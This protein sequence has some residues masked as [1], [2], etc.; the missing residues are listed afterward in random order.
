[1]RNGKR[2]AEAGM[3]SNTR[4][5]NKICGRLCVKLTGYLDSPLSVGSGEQEETDAD[6]LLDARGVPFIPG[7]TLAGALRA[8]NKELG[9][10]KESDQLFGTPFGGTPG[11]KGD[12]QSRI[13]C[14]DTYLNNATTSI[15]NGVKL[16]KNKTAESGAK[17]EI[18]VI[19][20]N[21][22]FC[23]RIEIIE[24]ED[25]LSKETNIQEVGNRDRL[26]VKRW[27]H[28]F[29]S[30][31]LRIGSRSNRGFGKLI[32]ESAKVKRFQMEQQDD[33]LEG[34]EWN[35]DNDS[36]FDKAE[37]IEC[38]Y[39]INEKR[40]LCTEHLLE[41]P[42]E[43]PYTL[44]VRTYSAVFRKGEDLP[45]Y[46]QL[47]VKN[48]GEQAVIPGSSIAGAFRSHIA[49]IVKRI[50]EFQSWEETQKKLEPFFGTWIDGKEKGETLLAS[51]VIFEE[52]VVNGGNGLPMNRVAIDRFTGGTVEG[53]LFEEIPW[54]NG[55][56]TFRVRWKKSKDD[57]CNK[58]SSHKVICGMLLWAI[59]DLQ[60]GILPLGGET[61]IG[62]GIF[63]KPKDQKSEICLDGKSL[64]E[65]ETCEYMQAAA[66]W[67]KG[68]KNGTAGK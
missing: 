66:L 14:Y 8:Y 18:Q 47:T 6:I 39:S 1:M 43:I 57:E 27:V 37:T 28:G 23:M 65:S 12:R 13:F 52:I 33:Y 56:V 17:Y 11:T 60:S 15:R 19:E 24:R 49:K 44:L 40:N 38:K 62:R 68:E 64:C 50:A 9:L 51:R 67:C 30:G 42:L 20:R 32:I 55:N 22:A 46:G 21:A 61:A 36:A 31:E 34:L 10:E 58:M 2:G 63:R 5:G 7:S 25:L 45:D 59:L 48:K 16:G 41:V 4:T 54:A 3:E 35:W 29:L 53:A 26:W